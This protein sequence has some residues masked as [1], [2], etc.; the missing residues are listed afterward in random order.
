MTRKIH[1]VFAPGVEVI[2]AYDFGTTSVTQIKGIEHRQGRRT[3]SRPIAL[4]ARNE[5]PLLTCQECEGIA[6]HFCDECRIE[7]D[8]EGVLCAEH[9]RVHPHEDY[10]EPIP[11]VNSPRMGMCGYTG[12]ADPPY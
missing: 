3:T 7:E 4:M 8:L 5:A 12:P 1:Q 11:I 10:G 9:A 6:T 2:H